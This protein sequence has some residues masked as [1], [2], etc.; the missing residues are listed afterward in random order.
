[1]AVMF[2]LLLGGVWYF[3][4]REGAQPAKPTGKGGDSGQPAEPEEATVFDDVNW[5]QLARIE[6]TSSAQ[7]GTIVLSRP[8]S[9]DD[10]AWR[11][12]KPLE[13]EADSSAVD[14]LINSLKNLKAETVSSDPSKDLQPFGLKNPGTYVDLVFQPGGK[15]IIQKRLLAGDKAPVGYKAY[16][17]RGDR[18]D[19]LLTG[20]YTKT[21]LEKRLFDLRQKTILSFEKDDVRKLVLDGPSGHAALTKTG[22]AWRLEEPAMGRASKAEVE[23]ILTALSGLRAVDVAAEDDADPASFGLDHPSMT[24]KITTGEQDKTA[25]REIE[26]GKVDDAQKRVYVKHSSRKPVFLV[27]SYSLDG[28][29][30]SP[31]DL[32][33]KKVLDFEKDAVRTI[34]IHDA[35]GDMR[36]AKRGEDEA[37]APKDKGAKDADKAK[38]SSHWLVE[39]P[40]AGEADQANVNQMLLT[41]AGLE[42]KQF[43]DGDQR[44]LPLDSGL[45]D[46]EIRVRLL[47]EGGAELGVLEV[48]SNV[49]GTGSAGGEGQPAIPPDRFVHVAGFDTVYTVA[50]RFVD[51]IPKRVDDL[52]KKKAESP[53]ETAPKATAPATQPAAPLPPAPAATPPP[54]SG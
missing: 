32:R 20:A 25:E 4:L 29:K 40:T 46:P 22:N 53:A 44:P 14:T 15:A 1:M 51:D 10:R 41:L 9:G 35:A 11:I 54:A 26:F 38:P 39:S 8:M 7:V 2:A 28:L 52:L 24:V 34:E 45:Q 42:A 23:K 30:K 37:A 48:G 16:F 3:E 19:V 12:V 6:L 36:I 50:G 5:D 27:S 13:T 49:S 43:L 47:G 18:T 17:K 21:S 31:G 33:D